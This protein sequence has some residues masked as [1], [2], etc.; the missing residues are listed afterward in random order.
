MEVGVVG[1]PGAAAPRPADQELRAGGESAMHPPL[2]TEERSVGANR[3]RGKTA[4]AVSERN[5]RTVPAIIS[6]HPPNHLNFT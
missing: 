4:L 5:Q 2:L 6:C 3:W 1:Q